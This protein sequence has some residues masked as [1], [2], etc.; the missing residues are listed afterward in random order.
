[1]AE[2]S[3]QPNGVWSWARQLYDIG[4][5]EGYC[6]IDNHIFQLVVPDNKHFIAFINDNIPIEQQGQ[7]K[8][9][10]KFHYA[11]H[12]DDLEKATKIIADN[13]A[14]HGINQFKVTCRPFTGA[15]LGKDITIYVGPGQDDSKKLSALLSDIESELIDKKIE[16]N[17]IGKNIEIMDNSVNGSKYAYYR[18]DKDPKT[19]QYIRDS[20]RAPEGSDPV[21]QIKVETTSPET[22]HTVHDKTASASKA[23]VPESKPVSKSGN[24]VNQEAASTS[25]APAPA[26]ESKPVSKSGNPV[27]QEAASTSKAPAPESKPVPQNTTG[28]NFEWL[29]NIYKKGMDPKNQISFY[30]DF[31]MIDGDQFM[32]FKNTK[33]TGE[34]QCQTG[35]KFHYAIHPDDLEKATKII[36]DNCAKHGI[37]QFKVTCRPFTGAQLGKDITIYVGP[38]Q[39][40]SKKLSALLSDIESE[41]IDKKIEPN[42]IGKNI[43]IMDN[44]VNGSKYAYYR[45]DK[46]PK[47]GQYIR[48]SFR[49]PEGYSDPV[50]QIEVKTPSPETA[51][52]NTVHD[53]TASTSKVHGSETPRPVSKVGI[54]GQTAGAAL[55]AL[56]AVV[57]GMEAYESFQQGKTGEGIYHT[58]T[59]T[60]FAAGTVA[61]IATGRAAVGLGAAGTAAG[62]LMFGKESYDSFK[63]G[64]YV[65]GSINAAGAASMTYSTGT[66]LTGTSVS[67]GTSI[68]AAPIAATA[69]A[70][71]AG[72]AIG[73]AVGKW[74]STTYV[75]PARNYEMN[76]EDAQ[77]MIGRKMQSVTLGMQPAYLSG[78]ID[79]FNEGFDSISTGNTLSAQWK[80]LWSN[81]EDRKDELIKE[82][83]KDPTGA[84]KKGV[85][86]LGGTKGIGANA[87]LIYESV[88]QGA[89][90]RT[91]DNLP[92]R[93]EEYNASH[94]VKSDISQI[95]YMNANKNTLVND[96]AQAKTA[97]FLISHGAGYSFDDLVTAARSGNELM[98]SALLLSVR[99]KQTGHIRMLYDMGDAQNWHYTG[100]TPTEEFILPQAM[101]TAKN[102]NMLMREAMK[103]QTVTP[104][105]F[106]AIQQAF[107]NEGNLKISEDILIG[108]LSQPQKYLSEDIENQ[109]Q[110][111]EG[112]LLTICGNKEAGYRFHSWEITPSVVSAVKQLDKERQTA[113]IQYA[114]EKK[115]GKDNPEI[116]GALEELSQETLGQPFEP[117]EEVA[118]ERLS[119]TITQTVDGPTEHIYKNPIAYERAH[120]RLTGQT[121]RNVKQKPR[122]TEK[123]RAQMLAHIQ[124]MEDK[125]LLPKGE[126]G[127]SNKEVYLYK[128][129]QIN[130]LSNDL[131]GIKINGE[132]T[133][134][135][136]YIS[137]N[138]KNPTAR[139]VEKYL[140]KATMTPEEQASVAATIL[141]TEELVDDDGRMLLSVHAGNNVSYNQNGTKNFE[142]ITTTRT[143]TEN[144][145]QEIT[146][147]KA[148]RETV[149]RNIEDEGHQVTR[150]PVNGD[151]AGSDTSTV[152]QTEPSVPQQTDS[153][154]GL[155]ARLGQNGTRVDSED[156][157]SSHRHP[158]N[159]MER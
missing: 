6:R 109:E 57:E 31:L 125:G 152:I 59:S 58:A 137:E 17:K 113:F 2:V 1:M 121:Y 157:D 102:M 39:D 79:Y 4:L 87:F 49:A 34:P 19:G 118:T 156:L 36:A 63:K 64:D 89:R 139:S 126:G 46:D 38:G 114:Q 80:R 47:T 41:L 53:K 54:V 51:R 143:I 106:S 5:R 133:T 129:Q 127:R 22:A 122:Y 132:K 61:P 151:Q 12:P 82:I 18:F 13:C 145:E 147:T 92:G 124:E 154:K 101:K 74:I 66:M 3:I 115:L 62:A 130:R 149:V 116:Q 11:I 141:K 100:M 14:K 144:H 134:F 135:G 95:F 28:Q 150:T 8:T 98:S 9:G 159:E 78:F 25:K 77:N 104:F 65:D 97:A 88:A 93:S 73:W 99:D 24:P 20:F 131:S 105:K 7:C 148:E 10:L 32:V 29:K 68:A 103:A 128:L 94:A 117:V 40:D 96:I 70:V 76:V 15:Q 44:S 52:V 120:A 112:V 42:K 33:V 43:E 84:Y 107:N 45:F 91:F 110:G 72:A 60:G 67:L 26:P 71:G 123:E 23:P 86:G 146:G 21:A 83:Q 35:L 56:G 30:K 37:N 108:M 138:G 155:S 119:W 90:P 136:E 48:D 140:K 158:T 142:E 85:E 16:P 153:G 75:E 69:A 111:K 27:N 50:A 81:H 55:S